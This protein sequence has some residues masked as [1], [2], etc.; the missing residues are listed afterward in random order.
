MCGTGMAC[1]WSCAAPWAGDSS[2]HPQWGEEGRGAR[3]RACSA[4]C[5]RVDRTARKG[6]AM[7]MS[8]RM[9][10]LRQ[11][12]SPPWPARAT[13]SLRLR[14]ALT[15]SSQWT[16][17]A[18]VGN[19]LEQSIR[20][21]ERHESRRAMAKVGGDSLI[22]YPELGLIGTR[23]KDQNF[24]LLLCLMS[25]RRSPPRS[26]SIRLVE[27]VV[28]VFR[29]SRRNTTVVPS[30][31]RFQRL[32][33]RPSRGAGEILEHGRRAQMHGHRMDEIALR[34]DQVSLLSITLA[35]LVV[36]SMIAGGTIC[37]IYGEERA[38][39]ALGPLPGSRPSRVPSSEDATCSVGVRAP[40]PIVKHPPR[41]TVRR[42]AS[43][44]RTKKRASR[45]DRGRSA[46]E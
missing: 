16:T 18:E 4:S 23:R 30:P 19:Y 28:K 10:A 6:L 24:R 40:T 36:L 39:I 3:T 14:E 15:Y 11:A 34:G 45:S 20:R 25:S 33:R 37:G 1:W 46:D 26:V 8:R 38:A 27:R 22:S 31:R 21:F 32:Q 41:E 29:G 43:A 35:A 12:S 44:A 42:S 17:L 7:M 2:A 9:K 5:G 13:S